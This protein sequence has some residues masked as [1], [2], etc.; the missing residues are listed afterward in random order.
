MGSKAII[1]KEEIKKIAAALFASK[2]YHATT[3]DD[4][5]AQLR[6]TKAAIYYHVKNKE[7]ILREISNEAT[8]QLT[9]DFN[10]INHSTLSPKEKVRYIVYKLIKSSAENKDVI[11]INFEQTNALPKRSYKAITKQKKAMEHIL[12]DVLTEGVEQGVFDIKDVKMASFAIL[13]AV[14]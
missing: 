3:L 4:I 14:M 12:Q 13:G 2:G 11:T 5:A 9:S 7:S 6:V 8:K 1:S 10:Q